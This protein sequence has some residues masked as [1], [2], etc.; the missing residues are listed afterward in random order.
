M[1]E[2]KCPNCDGNKFTLHEI[3]EEFFNYGENAFAR[4]Y[5]ACDSCSK[6]YIIEEK[7]TISSVTFEEDE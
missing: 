7:H 5:V 3:F 6:H 2:M 4:Y 1:K